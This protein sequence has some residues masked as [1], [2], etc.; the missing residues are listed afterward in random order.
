MQEHKNSKSMWLLFTMEC[1][2]NKATAFPVSLTCQEEVRNIASSIINILTAPGRLVQND[3]YKS[4]ALHLLRYL[5]R[6]PR[7]KLPTELCCSEF[8]EVLLSDVFKKKEA[9]TDPCKSTESLQMTG[10]AVAVSFDSALKNNLIKSL[11]GNMSACLTD[12]MSTFLHYIWQIRDSVPLYSDTL[13]EICLVLPIC[14]EGTLLNLAQ[15]AV[16]SKETENIYE[17]LQS[18]DVQSYI[19]LCSKSPKIFCRS[20]SILHQLLLISNVNSNVLAFIR[21]F[22][23][24]IKEQCQNRNFRDFFPSEYRSILV[25]LEIDPELYLEDFIDEFFTRTSV[26]NSVVVGLQRNRR[27]VSFLLVIYPKWLSYVQNFC[28]KNNITELLPSS[29]SLKCSKETFLSHLLLS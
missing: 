21:N 10:A 22:T 20:M 27:A 23:D 11:I 8:I 24:F 6:S 12:E 13:E 19:C 4:N 18:Y 14:L 9:F 28:I 15:E 17:I 7:C 29:K 3:R 16:E 1:D 26:L 25:A 2:H 5:I